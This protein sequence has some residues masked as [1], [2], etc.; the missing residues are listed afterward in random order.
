[1]PGT[2]PQFGLKARLMVAATRQMIGEIRLPLFK[3]AARDLGP[4]MCGR[5]ASS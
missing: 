2:P 4:S 1:M 5:C 3:T